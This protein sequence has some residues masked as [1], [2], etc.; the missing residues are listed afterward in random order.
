MVLHGAQADAGLRQPPAGHGV[1]RQRI[2]L[3]V[4]AGV[5]G[6]HAQGLGQVG[7]LV[8]RLAVAHDQAHAVHPMCGAQGAQFGVHAHQAV[9]DELDAAVDPRQGV[10]D[11]AVEHEHAPH[12]P[13]CEQGVVQRGMVIGA[14]VSAQPDQGA[15]QGLVGR[16]V[17][18]AFAHGG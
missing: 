18:Q 5:H 2:G 1:A 4:V 6:L 12:L 17:L 13:G 10:E 11:G 7:D 3:V 8:H 14:Q 15:V 9:A 16:G